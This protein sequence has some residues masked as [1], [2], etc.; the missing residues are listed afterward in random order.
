LLSSVRAWK[1]NYGSV[2]SNVPGTVRN[3]F[4]IDRES[5]GR[6]AA[7]HLS[8]ASACGPLTVRR[9]AAHGGRV[10]RFLLERGKHCCKVPCS[11]TPGMEGSKRMVHPSP[12]ALG[13][14]QVI[15][16]EAFAAVCRVDM[17]AH[18]GPR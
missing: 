4:H 15:D 8:G 13:Y 5:A 16:E 18:G 2:S 1:I 9:A 7:P 14:V 11:E 10:F 6:C 12:L 3:G 17:H